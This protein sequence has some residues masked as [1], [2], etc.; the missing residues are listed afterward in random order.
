[1]KVA[2]LTLGDLSACQVLPSLRSDG[3]GRQK[4][5]EAVGGEVTA[6]QRAELVDRI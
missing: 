3:M 4:S 2:R 6:R 1:M 5:A